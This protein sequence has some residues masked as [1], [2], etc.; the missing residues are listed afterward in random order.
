MMY[1]R[2]KHIKFHTGIERRDTYRHL[3]YER[4]HRPVSKVHHFL[5]LLLLENSLFFSLLCLRIRVRSMWSS[6][7]VQVEHTLETLTNNT[8]LFCSTFV[9]V[10]VV[11]S[12]RV[13]QPTI[14]TTQC[15]NIDGEKRLYN[16][17]KHCL[18]KVVKLLLMFLYGGPYWRLVLQKNTRGCCED[19]RKG[20][21]NS[22]TWWSCPVQKHTY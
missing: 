5:L 15:I 12:Y 8:F 1:K 13:I 11:I 14:C 9:T 20:N 3:S 10:A 18:L 21:R 2:Q 16:E 19:V 4:N 6:L 22:S 17:T 7:C